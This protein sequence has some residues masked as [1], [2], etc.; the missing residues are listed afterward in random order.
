MKRTWHLIFFLLATGVGLLAVAFFPKSSRIE[1]R[2]ALSEDMEADIGTEA[3]G[4][5]LEWDLPPG[6]EYHGITLKIDDAVFMLPP[7]AT[8]YETVL[9]GSQPDYEILI[10]GRKKGWGS[11]KGSATVLVPGDN[12]RFTQNLKGIRINGTTLSFTHEVRGIDRKTLNYKASALFQGTPITVVPNELGGGIM[13]A[14]IPLDGF[15]GA[16][17]ILL[18]FSGSNE[19]GSYFGQIRTDGENFSFHSGPYSLSADASGFRLL[20]TSV[21]AHALGEVSYL[22]ESLH[23]GLADAVPR[24]Y[25]LKNAQ[26]ETGASGSY[27]HQ[28]NGGI[29][30]AEVAP[31]VYYVLLDGLPVIWGEV[32]VDSW[33]TVSRHGFSHRIRPKSEHG[34]LALEVALVEQL[35]I[36]VYDLAIDPGHGGMDTGTTGDGFYESHEALKISKYMAKRFEEHGLKVRL[37]RDGDYDPGLDEEYHYVETPYY[38]G[39]R[40]EQV[41]R[42]QAKYLI[43]N[44]LNAVGGGVMAEG[45]E[46]YTSVMTDDSWSA[47]VAE[48]LAGSGRVARDSLQNEYRVSKGSF[49]KWSNDF[50]GAGQQRD[51]LFML[52]ETGG[53]R[54][55]ATALGRYNPASYPSIPL[56]GAEGMLIEYAYIDNPVEARLWEAQYKEWA[57]AVV[58]GTLAYLGIDYQQALPMQY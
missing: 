56:H 42:Y 28:N 47:S 41:Y 40:V 17:A 31:G 9:E 11:D 5:R 7:S 38:D 23:L 49:K 4:L 58:E 39:G 25:T 20:D 32:P 29:P 3:Y 13:E 14:N 6:G 12:Q 50:Y 19:N 33:H 54:S 21:G 16:A 55:G 52:R 10:A 15:R 44:H 27:G 46:I 22:G 18:E 45:F 24:S 34:L 48:K 26:G 35:P 8:S 36:E 51:Y 43:S 1:I 37:T 2:A 30:L 53:V 57:E